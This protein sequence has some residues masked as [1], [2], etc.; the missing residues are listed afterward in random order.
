MGKT[1]KVSVLFI[2]V[3]Y[4]TYA[5]YHY[6]YIYM[7]ICIIIT[8]IQYAY[9]CTQLIIIILSLLGIFYID[10]LIFLC[11]VWI[12]TSMYVYACIPS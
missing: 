3:Y 8:Y 9:D 7:Y 5:Y 4:V 11:C 10:V 1:T 2:Y 12:H 6:L